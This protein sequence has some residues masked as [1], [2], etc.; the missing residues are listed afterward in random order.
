MRWLGGQHHVTRGRP[1]C[2]KA[3]LLDV[4]TTVNIDDL[5]RGE[6][7]GSGLSAEPLLQAGLGGL[8]QLGHHHP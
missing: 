7:S 3:V 4:Q 8:G 5:E 1:W 6:P 2:S